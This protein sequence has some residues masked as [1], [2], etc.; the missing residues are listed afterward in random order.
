MGRCQEIRE[1]VRQYGEQ[2]GVDGLMR[3]VGWNKTEGAK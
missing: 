1:R 3:G 2:R